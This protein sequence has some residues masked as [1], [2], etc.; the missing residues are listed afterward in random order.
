[1]HILLVTNIYPTLAKPTHGVYV[2][3]QARSLISR[4]HKVDVLHL[5]R[6]GKR[7]RYLSGTI[8]LGRAMRRLRPDLVHAHYGLTGAVAVLRPTV[9]VVVTYHGSDVMVG[10][11]RRISRFAAR[12]AAAN[13]VVSERQRI[14]L[15]APNTHV[16]P[17]GVDPELFRPHSREEARARLHLDSA[18]PW[19]LFAGAF[20]NPVKNYALL[21]AALAE[22]P[23][24]TVRVKE[25]AGIERSDVA[26]WMA[27]ADVL[28]LTSHSEG[29]PMVT[30]EALFC[31]LPVIGTP[32]GDLPERIGTMDGCR[33]VEPEPRVVR[34]ALEEALARRERLVPPESLAELRLDRI[35]ERIESIYRD[36]L[37]R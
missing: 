20:D 5:R 19:I 21:E 13:V 15:G 34:A 24:R 31:G 18:E 16:I 27:A 17:C 23:R 32:V 1:M 29:S 30:K 36:V 11:Q 9:P 22:A 7:T 4:G 26:W 37:R 35:A 2:E 10:W 25:M 28:V 14:L 8:E 6:F 33:I 3:E 12:R